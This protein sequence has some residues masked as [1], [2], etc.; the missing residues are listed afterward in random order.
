MIKNKK[1]AVVVPAYNEEQQISMVIE[2]M[3][4]FVDRI[5]IV[6]D[7][8]SDKT[9]ETVK[10]FFHPSNMTI[11]ERKICEESTGYLRAQAVADSILKN[12]KRR[13]PKF[14]IYNNDDDARIVLINL[15]EKG[16][17]GGAIAVGYYWAR[18]HNMDCT[19]VMAG[20]GQ[21]DPGELHLLCQPVCDEGIDYV[22]G[23]RLIHQS[24]PLLVPP[25][26]FLGNSILSVLTKVA[27][28]YWHVS[29][30]QTGYTAISLKALNSLQLH[31]IY[32]TY[33]VPNDILVKLNISYCSLREVEIKPVYN[34]GEKSKMKIGKVIPRISWL[35]LKL[36]FLRLW[37]KYLLRDFHPLFLLYHAGFLFLFISMYYFIWELLIFKI[38]VYLDHY[39]IKLYSFIISL[40]KF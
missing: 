30:T 24:A 21:M 3:P 38:S 5:I 23:N 13:L 4:E 27:S 10:K 17:V 15:L 2:T 26:R 29:D 32:H 7:V 18:E 1:I 35:L 34:I 11:S 36:F 19:A 33:G 6:N 8:S 37:K 40:C 31:K 14:E 9:A 12:Q 22:K 39:S 16:F 25:I 28:G 20:D